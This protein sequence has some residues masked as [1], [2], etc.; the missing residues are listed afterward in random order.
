MILLD[1]STYT[2]NSKTYNKST[3]YSI[4]KISTIKLLIYTISIRKWPTKH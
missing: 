1:F 4:K 2:S 3:I